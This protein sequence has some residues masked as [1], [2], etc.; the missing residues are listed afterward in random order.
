MRAKYEL[1]EEEI[2]EA[3]AAFVNAKTG[4]DFKP[5]DVHLHAEQ[6]R[7]Q[8]DQPEYGHTITATVG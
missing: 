4:G 8:F 7:G 5:D 3:I 1:T 2:E 6:R